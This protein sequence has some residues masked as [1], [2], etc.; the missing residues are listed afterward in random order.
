LL[1]ADD[2]V[3]RDLDV[4]I[5]LTHTFDGDMDIT[6]IDPTGVRIP[7]AQN[8][9]GGGDNYTGTA[10]DD[11]AATPISAGVAPFGGAFR[12]EQ[13]L[14]YADGRRIGGLWTL[15]IVDEVGG[16]SG[17]L[18]AWQITMTYTAALNNGVYNNYIGSNAGGSAGLENGGHGVDLADAAGNQIGIGFG[19]NTI[20]GN[21]WG[22]IAGGSLALGNAVQGNYIGQTSTTNSLGGVSVF[23][24]LGN[25]VSDNTLARNAGPGVSVTGGGYNNSIRANSI[26]EDAG[27][28]IDLEPAGVTPN[29]PSDPDV[30]ANDLQN[31][32]VI[33]ALIPLGPNTQVSGTLNT[34]PSRSYRLDFYASPAADPSGYGEGRTWLG[35]QVVNSGA[36]T[37]PFAF[38]AP[39]GVG[40]YSATA[41]GPGGSTSEF[42]GSFAMPQE[43]PDTMLAS[44]SGP[45]IKLTYT[46]ACGAADHAVFWGASPIGGGLSWTNG[47]CG[48]GATGDLTFDPGIPAA[49]Q[50]FYWVVVGQ[51]FSLEGSYGQNSSGLERPEAIALGVCDEPLSIGGA[52][53]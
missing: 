26:F 1:V 49:G 6:L 36:G 5:N 3:I 45:S 19:G 38:I 32:P 13:P 15:E 9:G 40:F 35:S 51:T 33:T 28:G 53:P 16:D 7:L 23:I 14:A 27:L 8:R 12:P 43:V 20:S 52:C 37:V 24:G 42:S 44:K 18:L 21:A 41:T 34:E 47:Q 22:V 11:E 2:G 46:P 48:F 25:D 4:R 31:S 17:T 39:A 29:D 50:F 10:F 30:G